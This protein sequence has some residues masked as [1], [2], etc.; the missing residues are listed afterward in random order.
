MFIW[1]KLKMSRP[2]KHKLVDKYR[3]EKDRSNGKIS[4]I[5]TNKNYIY[6]ISAN[7]TK[8]L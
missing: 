6:E 4:E 7:V 1:M 2:A 8:S 3:N 5:I